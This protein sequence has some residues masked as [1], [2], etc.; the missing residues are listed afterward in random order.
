MADRASIFT[1]HN[2]FFRIAELFFKIILLEGRSHNIKLIFQFKFVL[3]NLSKYDHFKFQ[4]KT[5]V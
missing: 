3:K 4:D 2:I 1:I 5:R